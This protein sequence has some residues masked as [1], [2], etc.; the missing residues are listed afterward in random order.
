ME[1]P[2]RGRKVVRSRFHRA[3]LRRGVPAIDRGLRHEASEPHTTQEP[4]MKDS[5]TH[6]ALDTHKAEHTVALLLP[7]SQIPEV[8]SIR[9][10]KRDVRRM[11]RRPAHGASHPPTS[12]GAGELLLRGRRVRL[13]FAAADRGG[14]GGVRGDRAVSGAG[15]AGQAGQDGS[16]RCPQ[17]GGD[18]PGG[19]A[20]GGASSDGAGGVD[21]GS[22][23]LPRGGAAGPDADP[24]PTVEVPASSGPGLPCRS[25]VDA[26]TYAVDREHRVRMASRPADA[27]GVPVGIAAP[28]GACGVADAFGAF[29]ASTRSRR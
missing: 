15:P 5:T 14:A 25:P 3:Q 28:P 4:V 21:S 18:V 29:A 1:R 24:S 9:N 23:P 27:F 26:E 16:A 7:G 6:V 10:T 17:A 8:W 12:A 2:A 13:R 22:L 11:V 19:D 20:H